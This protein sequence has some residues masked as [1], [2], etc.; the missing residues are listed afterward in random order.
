MFSSC[1]CTSDLIL[2]L[3]S[4]YFGFI[5]YNAK[6]KAAFHLCNGKPQ[7][8]SAVSANIMYILRI[9][10]NFWE[11]K[12]FVCLFVLY[13]LLPLLHFYINDAWE[14]IAAVASQV[15]AAVQVGDGAAWL[16]ACNLLALVAYGHLLVDVDK[17]VVE[18]DGEL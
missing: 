9:G 1:G 7:C 2:S 18:V 3:I 13:V 15:E 14:G 11:K 5:K 4:F 6:N 12:A 8:L 10:L 16:N 17:A